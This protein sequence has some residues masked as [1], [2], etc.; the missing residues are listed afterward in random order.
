M[1]LPSDGQTRV[2]LWFLCVGELCSQGEGWGGSTSDFH[3][4]LVSHGLLGAVTAESLTVT[5]SSPP[6]HEA[7]HRSWCAVSQRKSIQIGQSHLLTAASR[8]SLGNIAALSSECSAGYFKHPV[9]NNCYKKQTS[10]L[11]K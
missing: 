6:S 11:L 3:V 2:S 10:E 4:S 7:W 8:E 9:P 1:F 5:A